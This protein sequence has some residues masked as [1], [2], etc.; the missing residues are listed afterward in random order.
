[1]Y[2][3]L[4]KQYQMKKL[5][6][7]FN[8]Y[9]INII[10]TSIGITW[11]ALH[12]IIRFCI[13]RIPYKL[14]TNIS[15]IAI[16][17]AIYLLCIH[18]GI[19]IATIYTFLQ[20]KESKNKI[21]LLIK[22]LANTLYWKPL[23][24]VHDNIIKN[25]PYSGYFWQDLFTV[26][27]HLCY[28]E[29][30]LYISVVCLDFIPRIIVASAFF[31]DIV[32]YKQFAYLYILLVLIIIPLTYQAFI[33][34]GYDFGLRNRTTI[35]KSLDVYHDIITDEPYF[36]MK[37]GYDDSPETL[38]E[39]T[40]L[41]YMFSSFKNVCETVK[42]FKQKYIGYILLYTSSCYIIGWLSYLNYMLQVNTWSTIYNSLLQ[43]QVIILLYFILLYGL[44]Y[45]IINYMYLYKPYISN[46]DKAIIIKRK[47]TKKAKH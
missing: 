43:L 24:A 42:D 39:Q 15:T 5:I 17:F 26:F 21:I 16:L 8:K 34:I 22:E 9:Y 29:K 25:I 44:I 36:E 6:D 32:I 41:W 37:E 23:I 18:T 10:L 40:N 47:R 19:L 13:T 35:K 46:L 12:I 20:Q 7:F 28:T 45:L 4:K 1:M 33:Y 11:I 27:S 38:E 3:K 2:I 14:H 30:R 31:I